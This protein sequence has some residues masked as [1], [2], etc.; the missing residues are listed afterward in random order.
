MAGAAQEPFV[1]A[2]P[3]ISAQHKRPA[4]HRGLDSFKVLM[5]G[6]AGVGKTS[7][8]NRLAGDPFAET[9]EDWDMVC[10]TPH[11]HTSNCRAHR[12]LLPRRRAHR[13]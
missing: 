5:V 10:A 7:L 8:L 3:H 11:T 2:F 9:N 1:P 6:D 12:A 4:A 13:K